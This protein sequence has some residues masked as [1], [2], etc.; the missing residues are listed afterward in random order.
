MVNMHRE[1]SV[2]INPQW[3]HMAIIISLMQGKKAKQEKGV[4]HK[5]WKGKFE[6]STTTVDYFPRGGQA[7][8]P[9]AKSKSRRAAAASAE[10]EA[11]DFLFNKAPMKV[12]KK[13]RNT[14]EVGSSDQPEQKRRK[15]KK[16]TKSQEPSGEPQ[17]DDDVDILG[18]HE[19]PLE[20]VSKRAKLEQP[21]AGSM[22]RIR[23]LVFSTDGNPA[24]ENTKRMPD[25]DSGAG[26][27]QVLYHRQLRPQQE[28][29]HFCHRHPCTAQL[30]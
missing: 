12:F 20:P 24:I 4:K 27:D 6:T 10:A 9:T 15:D 29:L 22:S 14:F 16:D 18:T 2:A 26:G 13:K 11:D 25:A 7:E 8:E 23:R 5:T 17:S 28:G 30:C 1:I 19:G 21:S 3:C